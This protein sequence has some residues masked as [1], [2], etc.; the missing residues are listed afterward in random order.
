MA[1]ERYRL[2][3]SFD[4]IGEREFREVQKALTEAN[5]QLPRDF[6]NSVNEVA[7]GLRDEA[8][9]QAL[10]KF[11]GRKGHT[12]LRRKVAAG[13]TIIQIDSGVKIITSM[14]EEDEAIIPRGLD[15]VRGWRHPVFGHKDRWVR[16]TQGADSWFLETMRRG[17][18]P[19][20]NRLVRNIN[21]TIEKIDDAGRGIG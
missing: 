11:T 7:R 13:V 14:P 4:V 15:G 10:Q 12:G 17:H 20:R 21:D 3:L 6:K 19:L 5:R 8:R 16:Q 1:I 18:E 9:Y 2:T